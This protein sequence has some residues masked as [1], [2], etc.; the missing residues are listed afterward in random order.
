MTDPIDPID[1]HLSRPKRSRVGNE[2]IEEHSIKD[3]EAALSRKKANERARKGQHGLMT[4]RV[5]PGGTAE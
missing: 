3:I 1:E 2:E 4:H 5:R